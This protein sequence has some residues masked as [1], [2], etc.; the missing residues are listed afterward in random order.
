M[1]TRAS[2]VAMKETVTSLF[3]QDN[4]VLRV[5]IATMAFSMGIDC[6]N[7]HQVIHWGAPADLEQNLQQIG[8]AGHDGQD[9]NVLLI[10]SK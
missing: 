3:T 8:R 1:Y 5:V 4:S 9:S 7:I 10:C 6:P 2:T